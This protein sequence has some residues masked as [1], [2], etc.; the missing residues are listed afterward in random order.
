MKCVMFVTAMLLSVGT[1]CQNVRQR[2]LST[3]ASKE[4]SGAVEISY[5]DDRLRLQSEDG[6]ELDD[7]QVLFQV[8]YGTSEYTIEPRRVRA[9]NE[10]VD[11]MGSVQLFT[12]LEPHEW[13]QEFEI[14]PEGDQ[15]LMS[16]LSPIPQPDGS[17]RFI[18][19][20]WSKEVAHRATNRKS[21]V[22]DGDYLD[23]TPG[24]S[25]DGGHAYFSSNRNGT[26]AIFR[27][28][29]SQRGRFELV[30]DSTTADYEPMVSKDGTLLVYTA[31]PR[32]GTVNGQIWM[33]PIT[34]GMPT[35]L[36]HGTQ[37]R[38]SC[39]EIGKDILFSRTDDTGYS[40][41]WLLNT[42][43]GKLEKLTSGPSENFDPAWSPDNKFVVFA[44]NRGQTP[45]GV[46]NF[47]IW[48]LELE[49]GNLRQLT[50]NASV[51]DNPRFLNGDTI[52]F[53]SNRGR[54]WNIWQMD[55]AAEDI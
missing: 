5:K 2:T 40:H 38:L 49:T 7:A 10:T 9:E 1:S 31:Q 45:E 26:P 30:T 54:Q 29:L 53:R 48:R 44:S 16:I 37:P 23:R 34:A 42:E 20:I 22:T 36:A 14:S 50:D 17:V 32:T 11:G 8:S 51:D 41:L 43:T 18:S 46:R 52:M 25:S 13:L 15:V 28:S 33:R 47:D 6:D 39:D 24:Y 4:E 19:R 12:K 55:L 21:A 27:V 3:E 35:M